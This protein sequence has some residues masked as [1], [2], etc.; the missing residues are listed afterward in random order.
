MSSR[1]LA[2]EGM[3][4]VI[5]FYLPQFHRIPENDEWWG[6]GFTE[7]TNV[8]RGRPQFWGH[9]QPHVPHP[10]IGYY[11]LTDASVME[12]QVETAR[13]FGIHG[14]CFY[15]YWFNGRRLLEM[16]TDRL[17]SSGKP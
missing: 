12:K 7:W 16:P 9:Y 2:S 1:S 3:P 17:I 11:D 15:Y 13:R 6:E 4:R 8:K 5:A 14:F 10:D